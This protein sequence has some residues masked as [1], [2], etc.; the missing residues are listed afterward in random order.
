MEN[1][2]VNM[3]LKWFIWWATFA[4]WLL[5]VVYAS[6]W[7][8]STYQSWDNTLSAQEG[9]ELTLSKWN[10]LV[11]KVRNIT[12]NESWEI[13]YSWPNPT[14]W[15]ALVTKTWVENNVSVI[16]WPTGATGAT[17]PA[18]PVN[19]SQSVTDNRTT[20]VPSEAAVKTYVDAQV[21]AAWTSWQTIVKTCSCVASSSCTCEPP[22]CPSEWTD[23][24]KNGLYRTQHMNDTYTWY[25]I[26]QDYRTCA[27][28]Q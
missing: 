15:S 8:S 6:N 2:F 5:W 28:K 19:I 17:G 1:T 25:Y 23:L 10:E 18:W 11:S 14:T 12:T 27:R 20:H 24:W 22:A 13:I 26:F 3:S 4:L 16:E 9:A 7:M 21:Q